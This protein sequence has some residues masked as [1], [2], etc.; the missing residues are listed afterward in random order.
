MKYK[1]SD[2]LN[3]IDQECA[4][5]LI[6]DPLD[7][8]PAYCLD[9][10]KIK[11]RVHKKMMEQ[12]RYYRKKIHRTLRYI[13]IAALATLAFSGA[14]FAAIHLYKAKLLNEENKSEI[15]EEVVYGNEVEIVE[16]DPGSMEAPG[17]PQNRIVTSID[18]DSPCYFNSIT[19]FLVEEVDGNYIIPE[20]IAYNGNLI[21]FTQSNGD[22]W[23]LKEGDTISLT[24]RKYDE[25]SD[26]EIQVGFIKDG[27]FYDNDILSN[28]PVAYSFTA[29]SAGEYFIYILNW[30]VDSTSY[31]RGTI[32]LIHPKEGK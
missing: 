26:K 30:N 3:L 21:C 32:S 17:I 2:L 14:V 25:D 12:D 10:E 23:E 18:G 6:Q 5:K 22:G 8:E 1:I 20:L 29:D 9:P 15:G 13:L 7:S 16:G 27:V 4:E 19:E 24:I 11:A 31:H 28:N